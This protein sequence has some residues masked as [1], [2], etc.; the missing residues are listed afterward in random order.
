MFGYV[1]CNIPNPVSISAVYTF[2]NRTFPEA[3]SFKGERHS[4]FEVVCVLSGKVGI[5]A[6]KSAYILSAGDAVIH[7]PNE[8]HSIWAPDRN[9]PEVIIFSFSAPQMPT[10]PEHIRRMSRTQ[11]YELR[12]IF[13]NFRQSFKSC[14]DGSF[15]IYDGKQLNASCVIKRLELLLTN[16]FFIQETAY[17]ERQTASS[18]TYT[19]ILTV[20][21]SNLHRQMS[22]DELATVCNISVPTLEKT[23]YKY[24]H[25]GAAYHFN[26][27]KMKKAAE[28]IA[29][30]K[31]VNETSC[32]LGFANQNYFSTAFKKYYGYPPS[33]LK[34]RSGSDTVL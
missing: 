26:A 31:N 3:Y 20:M 23:V 24:L 28:L 29:T 21:E 2:F 13:Y 11:C 10:P 18:D 8:F 12:D 25:C 32:A 1:P 16:V 33:R 4:F 5:T 22:V 7:P 9:S 15:K 27:L 34:N 30:G 6:D 14:D 19:R 17:V